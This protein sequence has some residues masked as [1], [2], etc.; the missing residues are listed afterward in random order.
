MEEKQIEY[1]YNLFLDDF[2][3]PEIA[4]QECFRD[5]RFLKEQ[6]EHVKSHEDFIS[7]VKSKFSQGS[8]PKLVSFDHDLADV[9]Y[10]HIGKPREWWDEYYQREDAEKTG[11]HS[12][13]WFIEFVIDNNLKM[14][15]III[16]TR[17][18]AGGPNIKALFD[19]Y[20]KLKDKGML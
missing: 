10:E 6:W 7:K 13:K 15:D 4:W 11:R 20:Y 19:T 17:N 5:S 8:F 12:A 16:H 14:P 2:R 18:T 9:H 3:T 1:N